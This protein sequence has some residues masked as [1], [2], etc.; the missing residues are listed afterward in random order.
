MDLIVRC[1]QVPG[2]GETVHG[3]E[4]AIAHGGKGAN[5]AVACSRQ[6]A[7]TMMIGR[8]G[9]D[10]FGRA[11]KAG[12]KA[13]GV[14]VDWLRADSGA[15]TGV[16]LILLEPDGHNRIIVI[17]GANLRLDDE[18]VAVARKALGKA[19]TLLVQLETPLPIVKA[20]AQA[21]RKMHVLTV[22][23]AGAANPAAG[24]PGLLGLVDVASPN[25]SEAEAL[26][27]IAV[28]DGDSARRAA[29]RLRELGARDV[30]VK[31]GERGAYW[32]G[33]AGEGLSPGFTITPVDTTAAGDAF[34][35]SLAVS[36]ASGAEMPQALKRANAAG[37]LACLKLGAQPSMPTA[38]E[39]DDFLSRRG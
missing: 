34:T 27:G 14:N 33:P 20:V 28:N 4:F 18:D 23:D 8:V 24:E 1:C 5:Q 26:T 22:L 37:A 15:A 38:A 19:D 12:L 10:D 39:V 16:A 13:E 6:G 7:Q 9:N 21:A 17:G 32:A 3:D 2:Q 36:L 31:L 30:V 35:A 29:A 25:E 11:T